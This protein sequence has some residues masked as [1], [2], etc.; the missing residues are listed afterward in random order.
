MIVICLKTLLKILMFPLKFYGNTMAFMM[1][2]DID[3]FCKS[4]ND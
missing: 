1:H 3:K 4:L 2:L